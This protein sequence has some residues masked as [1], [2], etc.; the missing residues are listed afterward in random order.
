MPHAVIC[1]TAQS[2]AFL[3]FGDPVKRGPYTSVN[4]CMVF[5]ICD[6]CIASSRI[7]A[8]SAV[9]FVDDWANTGSENRTIIRIIAMNRRFGISFSGELNRLASGRIILFDAVACEVASHKGPKGG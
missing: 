7:F 8:N 6:R 5:M 3:W 9:S 1:L 4:M 2:A